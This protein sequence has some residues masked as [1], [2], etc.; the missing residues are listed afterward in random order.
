MLATQTTL[1]L[2]DLLGTNLS[3][4]SQPSSDPQAAH[5]QQNCLDTIQLFKGTQQQKEFQTRPS[6]VWQETMLSHHVTPQAINTTGHHTTSP[7][8]ASNPS[9]D[10]AVCTANA[11]LAACATK[12]KPWALVEPPLDTW[13]GLHNV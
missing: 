4:P 2:H 11:V 9:P 7:Q 6:C 12:R 1:H 10:P 8:G 3:Q 13:K 5:A